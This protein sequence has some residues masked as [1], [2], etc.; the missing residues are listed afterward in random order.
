MN[1]I[2]YHMKFSFRNAIDAEIL[3]P[4]TVYMGPNVKEQLSI[5]AWTFAKDIKMILLPIPDCIFSK[6]CDER[7]RIFDKITT[8]F[9]K[10]IDDK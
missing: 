6:L 9:H 3:L 5:A 7:M 10:F 8:S 1:Y 2:F 4:W